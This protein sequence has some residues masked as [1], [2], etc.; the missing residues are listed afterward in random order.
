MKKFL[1][2]LVAVM[3]VCLMAVSFTSCGVPQNPEKAKANLEKNGYSVIVGSPDDLGLDGTKV[4]TILIA[5]KGLLSADSVT[6]I[7][8]KD[9]AAAKERY[10]EM[11]EEN[12][13]NED[14]NFDFGRSGKAV[15]YGHKNAIK[16]C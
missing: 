11:K 10:N 4:E 1:K 12:K 3:L 9:A 15:Y 16:A 14:S 13:D 5:T 7:Y 8:Y 2:S 6:I